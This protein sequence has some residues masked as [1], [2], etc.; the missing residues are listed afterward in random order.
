MTV[1]LLIHGFTGGEH[2]VSPLAEYLRDHGCTARTFTLKGLGGTREDMLAAGRRDWISRA[3]EELVSL[4][5]RHSTVHLIG[6]STGSLIAVHLAAK[7]GERIGRLILLST[8]VF[9]L[10]PREIV[11]T[12]FRAEMLRAYARN[13]I[14][15]PPRATREYFRLVRESFDFYGQVRQP[16]LIVQ[17]TND[18]LVR[19][20]S[21]SYLYA[22]LGTAD[23]KLLMIQHSGHLV[24]HCSEREVL[25]R[26]ALDWIC[27]P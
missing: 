20:R 3:E 24:C 8:P 2:E 6:F 21:A 4:L 12:L 1:C 14:T 17:G 9:P 25:F 18:H 10:N 15:T 11:K 13:A 22:H 23:K 27:N 5:A 16:V 26:E 7:Y 19:N